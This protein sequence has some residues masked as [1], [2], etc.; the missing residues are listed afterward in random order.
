MWWMECV[1]TVSKR[2]CRAISI[3]NPRR[4]R[5]CQISPIVFAVCHQKCL[6]YTAGNLAKTYSAGFVNN[7]R[8]NY[9]KH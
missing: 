9:T 3:Q 6:S 5:G 7:S 1:S 2:D 4:D 8:E